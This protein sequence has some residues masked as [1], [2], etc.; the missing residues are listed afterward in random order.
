[1][2]VQLFLWQEREMSCSDCIH[3]YV[4]FL[5]LKKE[6]GVI[7][8]CGLHLLPAAGLFDSKVTG[9]ALTCG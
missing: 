9:S 4:T 8:S 7:Y 6:V 1:M 2:T 5:G 3:F